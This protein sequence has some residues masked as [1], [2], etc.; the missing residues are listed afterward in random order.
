MIQKDRNGAVA[1]I[2]ITQKRVWSVFTAVAA[3]T[4]ALPLLQLL[5]CCC[6]S[7]CFA[8]AATTAASSCCCDQVR[9]REDTDCKPPQVVTAAAHYRS[10]H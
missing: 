1:D 5:L 10:R 9:L 2:N 7:Y 4:A 3:A 6:C 8:A